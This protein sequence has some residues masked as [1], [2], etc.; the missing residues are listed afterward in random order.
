[1][2]LHACKDDVEHLCE[3]GLCCGLVD[4]VLAGQVDVVTRADG[5]QDGSLMDFYVLRGYCCQQ[6]LEE[7]VKK[8]CIK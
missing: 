5:L 4:E 6:S 2:I 3:R 1:M 7:R 8:D